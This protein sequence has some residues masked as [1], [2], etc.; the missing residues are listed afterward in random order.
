MLRIERQKISKKEKPFIENNNRFNEHNN[1]Y[2]Y[3]PFVLCSKYKKEQIVGN[4][5]DLRKFE[6]NMLLLSKGF[7]VVLAD[8]KYI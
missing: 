1:E 8:L 2:A 4:M 7:L 5:S 6:K 3:W